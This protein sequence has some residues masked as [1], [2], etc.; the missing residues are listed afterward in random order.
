MAGAGRTAGATVAA[1]AAIASIALAGTGCGGGG[2]SPV[3][4]DTADAIASLY[5]IDHDGAA[6]KDLALAPYT[7]AF[8]RLQ[9]GCEGSAADLASSVARLAF[10]ATNG[11]GVPISNLK[12]LRA[13]AAAVGST[14]EDCSG[15]FVGVEARLEGGALD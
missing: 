8:Q 11:S 1:A 15:V 6:P 5:V 7:S 2:N 3:D 14:R 13:A 12:A 9:E 4:A 10:E